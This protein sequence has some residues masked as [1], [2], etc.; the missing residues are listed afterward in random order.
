MNKN[1]DEYVNFLIQNK[2]Y[3]VYYCFYEKSCIKIMTN[4]PDLIYDIYINE[5]ISNEPNG[6]IIGEVIVINDDNL[7]DK[8]YDFEEYDDSLFTPKTHKMYIEGVENSNYNFGNCNLNIFHYP[9]P[10]IEFYD[11]N[12]RRYVS[13][14]SFKKE[15]LNRIKNGIKKILAS[16]NCQKKYYPLHAMAVCDKSNGYLFIAGGHQGKTTFFLNLIDYFYPLNDDII[17]WKAT[18]N[19]I[20]IKGCGILPTI[21]EGTSDFYHKEFNNK[22]IKY[23]EKSV[24]LNSIFF[25]EFG[26]VCLIEKV[27][28]KDYLKKV[29]RSIENH[30]HIEVN[31]LFLKSFNVLKNKDFYKFTISENYND[32]IDYFEKWIERREHNGKKN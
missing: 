26:D 11:D 6:K 23:F 31:E 2:N 12:K 20:K 29:L 28:I 19:D 25:F 5:K 13:I 32:I 17:F 30:R 1:L 9:Y 3:N 7:F 14:V 16:F 4:L 15:C 18:D 27:E 21:R 24:K 22:S 8:R 10:G